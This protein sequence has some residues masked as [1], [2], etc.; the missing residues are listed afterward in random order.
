MTKARCEKETKGYHLRKGGAKSKAGGNDLDR[1]AW[2]R[3]MI[4]Y[5]G[6]IWDLGI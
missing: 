3:G 5:K 4:S 1:M 2:V 6:E